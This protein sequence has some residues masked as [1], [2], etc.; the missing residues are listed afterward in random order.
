MRVT[1]IL[2]SRML[3]LVTSNR[4]EALHDALLERLESLRRAAGDDAPPIAV[5]RVRT[6]LTR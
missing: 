1:T 2:R 6:A 5:H 3:Y 4:I